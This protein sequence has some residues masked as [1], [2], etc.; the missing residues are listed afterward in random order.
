MPILFTFSTFE[1]HKIYDKQ[2]K[3]VLNLSSKLIYKIF[4]VIYQFDQIQTYEQDKLNQFFHHKKS[5]GVGR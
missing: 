4:G 3:H 1:M 2:F 5:V